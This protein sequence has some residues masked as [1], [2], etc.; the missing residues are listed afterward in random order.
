MLAE[1]A[2][3]IRPETLLAWNKRLIAQKC[4]GSAYRNPGRP[5]TPAELSELVVRMATQAHALGGMSGA[6][7][8]PDN[9]YP[10]PSK[11]WIHAASR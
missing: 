6:I 8:A 1:V 7:V 5:K 4:D 2:P 10:L 9:C 3:I 11:N